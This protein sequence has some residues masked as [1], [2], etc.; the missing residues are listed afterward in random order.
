MRPLD[1]EDIQKC[2]EFM[3]TNRRYGKRDTLLFIMQCKLGYR[4][5]E[6]LSLRLKDVYSFPPVVEAKEDDEEEET[7]KPK[8]KIAESVTV[9]RKHMK[10]GKKTGT[11]VHSR[12]VIIPPV[13]HALLEDYYNELMAA[14]YTAD[15]PLFPSGS[16]NNALR[17]DSCCRNMRKMAKALEMNRVGTHS[18]R[19]TFAKNIYEKC[20]NDIMETKEALGHSNVATTQNYLSFG[21]GEKFAKVMREDTE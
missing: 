1:E 9:M 13:C 11:K 17:A 18:C 8:V 14:G 4:M 10:G 7:E 20:G 19:K 2:I 6:M 5:K 12:T 21:L 3:N 15:D 16:T